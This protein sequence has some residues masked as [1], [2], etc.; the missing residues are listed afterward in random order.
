MEIL[1][2]PDGSRNRDYRPYINIEEEKY[3]VVF[4][5]PLNYNL[6]SQLYERNYGVT[7]TWMNYSW[8]SVGS[9]EFKPV[10]RI[11]RNGQPQRFIPGSPYM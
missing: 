9:R 11:N 6:G 1:L 2:N 4:Y 7:P 8:Q 3:N 10:A 5:D